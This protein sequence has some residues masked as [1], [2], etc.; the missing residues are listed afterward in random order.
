MKPKR[1][2]L[3]I[4][5]FLFVISK[6]VFPQSN[7]PSAAKGKFIDRLFTGGNLGLQFGTE[8][9]VDLSPII[10]YKVTDKF[11]TGIGLKY[12]YYR[13]KY[14]KQTP[15]FETST[16]GG[17]IFSRYY[18][19][20]NIYIHAEYEVLNL[21]TIYMYPNTGYVFEGDRIWIGSL[22][23]GAGYRQSIGGRSSFNIMILYNFNETI[24]TPYTNP[25][26]RVGINLGI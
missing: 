2:T 15:A 14:N 24:Y 19:L 12:Q 1:I 11:V 26:I 7:Q 6:S 4:S 16:Y 18:I 5:I 25:V 21:A 22:L 17:S 20:D 9:I 3:F 13:Y 8:T 10:G 23:A